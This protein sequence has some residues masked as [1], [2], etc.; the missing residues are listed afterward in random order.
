MLL[1]LESA[2][3]KL[4]NLQSLIWHVG[5]TA[6]SMIEQEAAQRILDSLG[7]LQSLHTLVVIAHADIG[8]SYGPILNLS[9]FRNIKSFSVCFDSGLPS[10]L[11]NAVRELID[12]NALH[13]A[14]L[15]I[16]ATASSSVDLGNLL[17]EANHCCGCAICRYSASTFR[18]QER[19]T[20]PAVSSVLHSTVY[21]DQRLA[22]WDLGFASSRGNLDNSP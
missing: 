2:L 3:C 11:A 1:Y 20:P 17:P 19:V 21:H 6:G 5:L 7:P 10:S 12:V 15:R 9:C 8:S 16:A 18:I 4:K 22:G 14:A 13:L